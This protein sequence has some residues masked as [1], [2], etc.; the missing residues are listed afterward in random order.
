MINFP[1]IGR[2][3]VGLFD[4]LLQKIRREEVKLIDSLPIGRLKGQAFLLNL[5]KSDEWRSRLWIDFLEIR[6]ENT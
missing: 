6:R 4:P 1:K 2:V 5:P 3:R